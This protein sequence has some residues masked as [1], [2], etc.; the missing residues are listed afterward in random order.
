VDATLHHGDIAELFPEWAELFAADD[1][2][3]PFQ[4]PAWASAWWRHWA[5]ESRPWLLTVRDGDRLVG[6]APLRTRRLLGV[7]LLGAYEEP[8]DYWDVVARP[9]HRTAVEAVVGRELQRHRRDWDAVIVSRLPDSSSTGDSL[10]RCG[11]RAVH[12]SHMACPA[13][14]LPD[15]FDAY[16]A[17][18]SRDRRGNVRRGLRKLDR[19]ELE[20]R[21]PS[22]Q[23]LPSAIDRWQTLRIRQWSAKGKHMM[24]QH[25]EQRFRNFL[26]DVTTELVPAGL[27]VVWEFLRDCQVVGSFINFCDARSFYQYLG[28]FEPDLSRLSI[29]HIAIAEGI[30]SSIA[31]ARSRYDFGRGREPYKYWYGASDRLSPTVVLASGRARSRLVGPVGALAARW[32]W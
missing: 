25:T 32:R 2:A 18:L 15:S 7:R 19:G 3:T 17:T 1:R 24:P 20:L 8:G 30:R 13:L 4:S 28:A 14:A 23:D 31:A 10:E 12:R 21:T 29:G 5:R 16:L 9:E 27:A 26:V 22:V 11:L 6:L